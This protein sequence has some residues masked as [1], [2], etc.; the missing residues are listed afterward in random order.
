MDGY[1][2]ETTSSSPPKDRQASHPDRVKASTTGA[3]LFWVVFREISELKEIAY[4]TRPLVT[5]FSG[6]FGVKFR[7]KLKI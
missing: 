7:K 2:V 6:F 4:C 5:I 1:R 3:D